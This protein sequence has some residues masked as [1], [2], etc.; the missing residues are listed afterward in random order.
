MQPFNGEFP[1]ITDGV[2]S[3]Q[4]IIQKKVDNV[5]VVQNYVNL[6]SVG[7]TISSAVASGEIVHVANNIETLTI[8]VSNVNGTFE[9][10]GTLFVGNLRIGDFS[11]DFQDNTNVLGGY[12]WIDTPTYTTSNDSSNVFTDPGHGLVYVDI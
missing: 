5:L 10:S 3:D 7:E 6:P 8:Y 2:I 11:E 1:A 4:H 9:Q 12:W